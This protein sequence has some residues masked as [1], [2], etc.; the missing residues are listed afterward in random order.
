MRLTT[1]RPPP[2]RRRRPRTGPRTRAPWTPAGREAGQTVFVAVVIL[3]RRPFTP[4]SACPR[5]MAGPA[6]RRPCSSAV[7]RRKAA[8]RGS[9]DRPTSASMHAMSA[10]AAGGDGRRDASF[11]RFSH[12]PPAQE[13][14]S[15]DVH[16]STRRLDRRPARRRTLSTGGTARTGGTGPSSGKTLLIPSVRSLSNTLRVFAQTDAHVIL[17]T[18]V[19]RRVRRPQRSVSRSG[20]DAGGRPP[21]APICI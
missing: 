4:Q 19:Q 20:G 13:D 5:S 15:A 21:V 2:P 1:D 18:G 10:F 9:A 7:Q 12:E 14:A 8:R 17:A 3:Y 16:V 11:L 6:P